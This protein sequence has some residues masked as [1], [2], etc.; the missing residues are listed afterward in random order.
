M[1][2]G[3]HVSTAG[4]VENA[5]ARGVEIGAECIQIF[6]SS[7]RGW[8]YKPISDSSATAFKAAVKKDPPKSPVDKRLVEKLTLDFQLNGLDLPKEKR[9]KVTELTVAD[10]RMPAEVA[11]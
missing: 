1:L 10:V 7:P 6:A 11:P 9:E 4:G 5:V 3:A 2:I 8:A